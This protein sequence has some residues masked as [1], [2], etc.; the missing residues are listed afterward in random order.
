MSLSSR[1]P[2]ASALVAV[3][4]GLAVLAFGVRQSR[5]TGRNNQIPNNF[6]MSNILK[7]EGFMVTATS[8]RAFLDTWYDW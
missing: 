8:T 5:A 3:N 6:Q 1:F 7:L 2:R 4:C